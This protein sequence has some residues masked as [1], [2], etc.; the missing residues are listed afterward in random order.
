MIDSPRSKGEVQSNSTANNNQN[1]ISDSLN[2][3]AFDLYRE[4]INSSSGENVF[5]SPYSI[6]SA[7]AMVYLGARKN[8]KSQMA[9]ALH[10]DV[11]GNTSNSN[12]RGIGE[13]FKKLISGMEQ[14]DNSNLKLNVA[15]RLFTTKTLTLKKKYLREVKS[16][17]NVSVKPLDF[18]G[19][20]P[21]SKLF[22]NR[23]VSTKTS[24]RINDLISDGMIKSDT[25]LILV[26]AIYFKGLWKK[27]FYL[28]S[29]RKQKF[30]VSR[31]QTASVQMMHLPKEHL[32]VH[33]S[34]ELDSI[35]AELQYVGDRCSMFIFVPRDLDGLA[36]VENL[37]DA[38]HLYRILRSVERT[39]VNLDLPRFTMK[40]GVNLK[41]TLMN[42]GIKDGFSKGRADLSGIE[43]SRRLSVDEAV[44]KA[45]V[46]VNENGTEAAGATGISILFKSRLRVPEYVLDIKADRPF[47]FLIVEK[48]SNVV[49]FLGRLVDPRR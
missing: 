32:N 19:D 41:Q 48:T 39:K 18:L 2:E 25:K 16:Y 4:L 10:L 36:K 11:L 20:G 34:S 14:S 23:W 46:E 29:T 43:G 28:K 13:E 31:E 35:V 33:I 42:V 47:L 12:N 38:K 6:S 37:L 40:K 49:L 45:F 17:L 27:S 7:L 5:L 9:S 21:G 3:F 26:N 15:N 24:G 44:H 8:T 1:T 22:I 30:H